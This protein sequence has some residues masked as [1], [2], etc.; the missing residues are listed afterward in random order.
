[1]SLHVFDEAYCRRHSVAYQHIRLNPI[2]QTI[3]AHRQPDFAHRRRR[4]IDA[5]Q[6]AA[7]RGLGEIHQR[8][9]I[10]GDL[11]RLRV[12]RAPGVSPGRLR[13]RRA[14]ANSAAAFTD[15]LPRLK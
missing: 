5:N 8:E 4:Q 13:G 15:D 11:P 6:F 3:L 2:V 7:I 10:R 14:D 12:R 9:E 1:M